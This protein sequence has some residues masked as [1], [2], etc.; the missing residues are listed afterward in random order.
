MIQFGA[1]SRPR[2]SM[3][4]TVGI[5]GALLMTML[6][7]LALVDQFARDY[8]KRQAG[9]RLQQIVWQMRDALNR[10]MREAVSDVSLLS[11]LAEVR[12]ARAPADM[13]RA[14][15]HMQR[16]S[17][18]YAWIGVAS[19]DGTV[20]AATQG[21][22]EGVDVGGAGAAPGRVGPGIC[23]ARIGATDQAQQCAGGL[24]PGTAD[25]RAHGQ[26]L[27]RGAPAVVDPEGNG[28]GKNRY[29]LA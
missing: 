20:F 29:S 24:R 18:N 11:E 9:V 4:I 5:C 6:T 8:A 2:L 13:R 1:S 21:S 14:M 19:P 10:G 12:E 27:P 23:P 3:M 26:R 7:L 22:L 16:I 15:E 17:P 25:A 28:G